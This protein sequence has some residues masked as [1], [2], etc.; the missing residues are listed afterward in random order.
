MPANIKN[1]PDM[2]RGEEIKTEPIWLM[3]IS[4]N[5]YPVLH[6]DIK[7]PTKQSSYIVNNTVEPLIKDTP[8]K[9]ITSEQRTKFN[10]PNGDFPI[11]LNLR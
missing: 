7:N 1:V 9:E 4:P 2:R 10:V 6:N 3:M 5:Q 11:V 8:I